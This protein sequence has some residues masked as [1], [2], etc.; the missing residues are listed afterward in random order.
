MEDSGHTDIR[1]RERGANLR[2]RFSATIDLEAGTISCED[3]ETLMG[4]GKNSTLEIG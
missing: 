1:H 2:E 3:V 4:N